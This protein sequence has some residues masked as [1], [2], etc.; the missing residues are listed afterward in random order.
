MLARWRE[1]VRDLPS[2][3]D[4]DVPTL[5][6]HVPQL[7]EEL[8]E[9]LEAGSDETIA[10]AV[11]AVTPPAHG[12][13]RAEDGFDIVEVVA[14]Y[15]IL[16]GCIHDL[17]DRNELTL[18][19]RSFHILNRVLDGAIG[20]A[21]QTHAVQRALEVQRRREEHLAFVA[22]DLRTPLNAIALATT[23]LERSIV[24]GAVDGTARMLKVLHRNADFLDSLIAEVL[25]ENAN[26]ETEVGMKLERRRF[27]L[28]PFVE[29]LIYDLNP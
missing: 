20:L 15:N 21:V 24:A 8:A 29:R 26:L 4:L 25:K 7:I 10:E 1:K 14:E 2:A 5:D 9:A 22:H 23:A 28:W 12:V 3:R 27:D 11:A 13:Q 6:D 19:G 17:A 16:R 18:R